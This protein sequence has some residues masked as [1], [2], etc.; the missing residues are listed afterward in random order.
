VGRW[1]GRRGRYLLDQAL[2]LLQENRSIAEN[3]ANLNHET[4]TTT[5]MVGL[6]TQSVS[7][8]RDNTVIIRRRNRGG[9]GEAR[10][11]AS[12]PHSARQSSAS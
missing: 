10:C 2:Q 12:H 7:M 6:I 1:G 3:D 4:L 5:Q 8:Q 11:E 9:G